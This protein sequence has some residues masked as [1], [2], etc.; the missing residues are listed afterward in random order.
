[1]K[2]LFVLFLFLVLGGCASLPEGPSL[3]KPIIDLRSGRKISFQNLIESIKD[4][5]VTIYS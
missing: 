1:M 3:Q 5:R 4:A 2:Y